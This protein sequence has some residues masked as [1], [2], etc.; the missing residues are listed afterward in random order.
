MLLKLIRANG[1]A[2]RADELMAAHYAVNFLYYRYL[3][4]MD[5]VH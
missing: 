4:V 3:K 5:I 2:L 1:A